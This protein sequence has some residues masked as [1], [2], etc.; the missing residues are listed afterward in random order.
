MAHKFGH[1]YRVQ[2]GRMPTFRTKNEAH[3]F[4]AEYQERG[5]IRRCAHARIRMVGNERLATPGFAVECAESSF[6]EVQVNAQGPGDSSR[7][8]NGC[9][10][11]CR[12]YQY[13]FSAKLSR[14]RRAQHPM[15]WFERQPS[16]VKA[17]IIML[18]V[19]VL[20]II[21]HVVG[22]LIGLVGAISKLI[23]G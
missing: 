15:I 18:P 1:P 7:G 6:Q 19:L 23:R 16:L 3:E 8:F 21:Y 10:Q 14:W 2:P 12:L 11:G 17:T 4:L 13:P 22:D 9:P 20:A 5:L